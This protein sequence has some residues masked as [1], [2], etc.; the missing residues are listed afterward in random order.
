MLISVIVPVF[1]TAPYIEECIISLVNQGIDKEDM[2]IICIDDGSTDESY[3]ILSNLTE[4]YNN[5]K[6]FR[7]SN[8]GVSYT[9]NKG[10][11]LA[12][13]EYIYF[14]DSDDILEEDSL[15]YIINK[16]EEMDLDLYTF[17]AESF[18]DNTSEE[19]ED[20]NY[21]RKKTYGLY[22]TGKELLN[23]LAKNK[24]FR[25]TPWLFV[26]KTSIIKSNKLTFIE[27][28]LHEDEAF[29]PEVYL[30][31][32]KC[33]HEKKIFFKRRVRPNSTMTTKKN[34]E[35]FVGY[36]IAFKHIYKL[37]FKYG[38]NYALRVR[39]GILMNILLSDFDDLKEQDKELYR[40]FYTDVLIKSKQNKFFLWKFWL[41][42][43]NKYFKKIIKE[44]AKTRKQFIKKINFK[45]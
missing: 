38:K 32:N 17:D 15:N 41:K 10:I 9:R 1:N 6:L 29:T 24:D 8:K 19:I 26:T 20:F 21:I 14:M 16:M 33:M 22:S 40:D 18:L 37:F 42:Y 43:H 39:L 4:T 7:Q 28:I 36:Y 30:V 45:L 3:A 11:S 2:E 12:N 31:S 35:N 27:G 25:I 13:G 23:V 44:S 34:G 5:I